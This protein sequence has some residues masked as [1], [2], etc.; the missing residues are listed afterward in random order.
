MLGEI[1]ARREVR[2]EKCL[3][4]SSATFVQSEKNAWGRSLF[5][6]PKRAIM[7]HLECGCLSSLEDQA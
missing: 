2:S 1:S 7:S 6:S 4:S 5:A 3:D